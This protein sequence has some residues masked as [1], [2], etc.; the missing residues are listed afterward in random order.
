MSVPVPVRRRLPD[1]RKSVTRK[2][3]VRTADGPIKMYVT[4]GLFE[5]GSPGELFL[6]V[7]RQGSLLS[8]FADAVALS[9]SLG[10]Q[11]GVPIQAFITKFRHAK[12]EP[13][14]PT[15]WP[16]VPMASSLL[17]LLAAWLDDQF[18]A[19]DKP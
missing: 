18:P 19:S 2:L 11:W 8:G 6:K 1:E 16:K 12:F 17:D 9:V 15:G 7:D 13:S 4:V 3:V 10:L 5:D 14:G